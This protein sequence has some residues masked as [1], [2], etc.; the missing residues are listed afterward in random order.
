MN[1][2]NFKQFLEGYYGSS[3]IGRGSQKFW[4]PE[5]PLVSNHPE[6]E[7]SKNKHLKG[8]H[9]KHGFRPMYPAPFRGLTADK[10]GITVKK[11]PKPGK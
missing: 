11:V 4:K 8:V 2:L 6:I 9:L 7:A 5:T 3:D 1:E 10:F